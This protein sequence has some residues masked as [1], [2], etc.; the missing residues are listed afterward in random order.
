MGK[1]NWWVVSARVRVDTPLEVFWAMLTNYEGLA[2]FIPGLFE[3]RLLDQA[4]GLA[5]LYQVCVTVSRS[6]EHAAV[7]DQDKAIRRGRRIKKPNAF[8]TGPDWRE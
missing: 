4:H 1:R 7:D 3:C 5:R 2:N 6:P 8:V